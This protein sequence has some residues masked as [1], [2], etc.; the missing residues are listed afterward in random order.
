MPASLAGVWRSQLLL[1]SFIRYDSTVFSP[2]AQLLSS[3]Q[4]TRHQRRLSGR[5]ARPTPKPSSS[6]FTVAVACACALL[7]LARRPTPH[8]VTL[9]KLSRVP[10]FRVRS[11]R[12]S[13]PGTPRQ[14]TTPVV[15]LGLAVEAGELRSQRRD[16]IAEHH[17]WSAFLVPVD[18]VVG[19]A[20]LATPSTSTRTAKRLA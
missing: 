15:E 20:L 11:R 8:T 14:A 10:A 7:R 9:A 2:L 16:A 12:W 17:A 19:G 1:G 5:R 18:A 6:K 3:H 4:L 13:S